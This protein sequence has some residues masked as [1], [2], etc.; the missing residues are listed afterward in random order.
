MYFWGG[1]LVGVIVATIIAIIRDKLRTTTG[2]FRIDHS[3]PE[4]DIFRLDLDGIDLDN[5]SLLIMEIDHHADLSQ[6]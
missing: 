1:F 4:K 6:K 2:V 5:K 3:N